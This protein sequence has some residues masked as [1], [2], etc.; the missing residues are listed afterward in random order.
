M[1]NQPELIAEGI[2]NASEEREACQN[3]ALFEG[4]KTPFMRPHIPDDWTGKVLVI[5]E[6][7]GSDED[8][9]TH[10]PLTGK[11]GKDARKYLRK[12]GFPKEDIAR[13]NANICRPNKNATPGIREIRA[14]RP[15]LLDTIERLKPKIVIGFGKNALKAIRN[16]NDVSLT[17]ARGKQQE[18]PGLRH[19]CSIFVTYHPAAVLWGATHLRAKIISDLN[20]IRTSSVKYPAEALPR[21]PNRGIDTEYTPKGE[22]VTLAVSDELRAAVADEEDKKNVWARVQRNIKQTDYL[23]GH[24]LPGDIDYLVKLGIAKTSWLNGRKI[25]DSFL[26]ARMVDE[27]MRERGS[28]SLE[29]LICTNLNVM[30]WKA[31]TQEILKKTGDARQMTYEQRTTRCRIDA[32]ASLKLGRHLETKLAQ[33][34]IGD[35]VGRLQESLKEVERHGQLIVFTHRIAMTLHRVGLAGAAVNMQRF[36]RLGKGWQMEASKE[37]DL[38]V[39]QAHTL[40][41]KEFSPT[42]D[43]HLRVLLYK[44]LKLPITFRTEVTH[45]P[46]VNK[47]ALE[48]FKDDPRAGKLVSRILHFNEIDKLASTW[49]ESKSKRK[50]LKELIVPGPE[51]SG[52]G[53]LHNWI[54]ALKAR[55]GRRTSGGIDEE[56][57]T[58]SRNSQNWSPKARRVIVSRWKGSKIAVVDFRKLEPCITSWIIGD[59]N[60]LDIFLNRGGYVDLA[61][62]FLGKKIKDE[63]TE[64]KMVKSLWLGLT[65]NM[66]KGLCAKNLWY[67]LGIKF[68]SDWE[69]HKKLTGKMIKRFFKKYPKI[70]SYIRRQIRRL[71]KNQQIISPDGAIRHLPHDGPD[72]PGY[73]HLE[74]QAV[75]YP[76]QRFAA[77][78][79]GSAMIDYEES[80]L[81]EHKLSYQDWHEAVLLR[82]FELPCSPMV[83][84]IHDAVLLDIHLKSGKKDLDLLVSSMEQVCTLRKMVPD[85]NITLKVKVDIGEYWI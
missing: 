37:R 12:A 34:M 55:T 67:K 24:S 68:S 48:Q 73:W 6:A 81:K 29:N 13:T 57:H 51:G 26:L 33:Q 46:Q 75:N 54:F 50:S 2:E 47:V 43:K 62:D 36:H 58:E 44:K 17:E 38:I 9:R 70:K 31:E 61:A 53:L 83:N 71:E 41:M 40:G 18:M 20:R 22:L 14:C 52:L 74:N 79:T 28:Y 21:Q 63:T 19:P 7:P 76:I 16:R 35:S 5:A 25:R 4:C 64:Y 3:C 66:K 77:S 45:E 8:Q 15:F 1:K 11:A 42:H 39:K 49:Y 84:E 27:N 30:P 69:E 78:I 60:L 82:P 72:T 23:C 80:L 59:E 56:S 85:F 10:R 32:W 65:Y